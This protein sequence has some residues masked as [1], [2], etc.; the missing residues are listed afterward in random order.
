MHELYLI[1]VVIG[2]LILVLGLFSAPIKNN[3]PVSVPLLSMLLGIL[4]GPTGVNFLDSS[5]WVARETILEEASRLT[6]AIGLMGVALRLPPRYF[7]EHRRTQ[8][9]L[10]GVVMPVMWLIGSLLTALLL[11]IPAIL[12]FLVGA[13]VTPTDPIVASSIVTSESA[14][15]KIPERVR[16]AL[17]GESGLNDGLAYLF[18]LLPVLLLTKAPDVALKEWI[19]TTLL[20]E[21]CGAVILGLALG[22]GSGRL[23]RWA[24]RREFIE[25]LSFLG[26]TVALALLTLGAAKL[27][28]TDGVL[29][30]F[31]AGIAFDNAVGG[32]ER[33]EEE[34]MQEMVNQ[35]FSVPIF[36]LFGLMLPVE[37]WLHL[38]WHGVVLAVA[39]LLLR[40]LPAVLLLRPLMK[41]MPQLR[42]GMFVG[43][44]GPVGVS[45]MLYAMLAVRHTGDEMVWGVASL[46]ICLSI[47][48]HGITATPM[49][50]W[51]GHRREGKKNAEG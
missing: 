26:H 47:F 23:L 22:Y 38:G 31:I 43:W 25:P 29:A 34:N 21:V 13:V 33:A 9:I 32:K 10:I 46:I 18:V 44:F 49:T 15:E 14:K 37:E 27:V 6:L 11:G 36:A 42:D 20:H 16:N 41:Q 24:E 40:R 4:L 50:A 39:V 17:S 28:G 35:F 1:F 2:G 48:V 5:K 7:I 51:Y 19:L 12:A 8:F 45:A 30:V 3:L